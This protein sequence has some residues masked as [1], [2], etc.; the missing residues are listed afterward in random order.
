MLYHQ[1][2]LTALEPI[3]HLAMLF[4]ALLTSSRRFPVP[5]RGTSPYSLLI[6]YRALVVGQVSENRGMASLL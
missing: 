1:R 2:R 6:M 5:R 4:L 3:F